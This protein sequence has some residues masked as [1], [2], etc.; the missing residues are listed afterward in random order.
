[1]ISARKE[2]Y[3]WIESSRGEGGGSLEKLRVQK[4][5]QNRIHLV[6]VMIG[7]LHGQ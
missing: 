3:D 2:D 4:N 1:M 6:V 5:T 7:T